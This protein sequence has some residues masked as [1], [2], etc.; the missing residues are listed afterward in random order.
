M[1]RMITLRLPNGVE[2]QQVTPY[3]AG[4]IFAEEHLSGLESKGHVFMSMSYETP[5]SFPVTDTIQDLEKCIKEVLNTVPTKHNKDRQGIAS[6]HSLYKGAKSEVTVQEYVKLK[7]SDT[8]PKVMLAN[9]KREQFCGFFKAYK[10][11][12]HNK[13]DDQEFDIIAALGPYRTFVVLEV[14]NA[15]TFTQKDMKS[16]DQ[17]LN[18]K[19]KFFLSYALNFHVVI[20]I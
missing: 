12:G 3:E 2:P 15:H 11:D 10:C 7:F 6:F 13:G 19:A 1:Q 20:F 8:N 9:F 4:Q 17:T 16:I 14:K 5:I 18:R